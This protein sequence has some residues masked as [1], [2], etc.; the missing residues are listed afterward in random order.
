M[1]DGAGEAAGEGRVKLLCSGRCEGVDK[2]PCYQ[3]S[4]SMHAAVPA[5]ALPLP[6]PARPNPHSNPRTHPP[7]HS[8]YQDE[9]TKGLRPKVTLL[10]IADRAADPKYYGNLC[11]TSPRSVEACLRLGIDP[12]SLAQRPLDFYLKRERDADL[13]KLA[14]DYEERL[15]QASWEGKRGYVLFKEHLLDVKGTKDGDLHPTN[16]YYPT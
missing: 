12:N 16:R 8:P 14:F 7:T 2:G 5:S 3:R 1:A 4:W 11:P 13:A 9:A 6:P 15:R 10:D